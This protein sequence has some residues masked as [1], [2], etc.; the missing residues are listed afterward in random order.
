MSAVV[1]AVSP[2]NR[3]VDKNLSGGRSW[4]N[5]L[6]EYFYRCGDIRKEKERCQY[7]VPS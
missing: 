5:D 1:S 7:R 3:P 4:G 2:M 6:R